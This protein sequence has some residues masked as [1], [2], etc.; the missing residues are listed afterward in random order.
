ME[1]GKLTINTELKTT[2]LENKLDK[3]ESELEVAETKAT[4]A[5]E[6]FKSLSKIIDGL[7]KGEI[8]T[9][10]YQKI[11]EQ[12]DKAE[13]VWKNA[14]NVVENLKN[15]IVET[16]LEQDKLIFD[17][18]QKSIKNASKLINKLKKV[19]LAVFGIRSVYSLVSK[20][21]NAYLSKDTELA[22][23]LQNVWVGLGSFLAPALEYVSNI[24][25]KALGYLN[26]F[27]KKLTGIDFIARANAKS[28]NKQANAQKN[29]NKQMFSFD[30]ANKFTDT[31]SLN[32]STGSNMINVPELDSRITSKLE[33][34]ALTLKENWDLIKYLGIAFGSVFGAVKVAQLLNSIGT[35]T[36]G[37][38]TLGG[39]IGSIP[40]LISISVIAVGI[41]YTISQ[42]SQLRADV[43]ETK[44][45][46]NDLRKNGSKTYKE[47]WGKEED[48]TKIIQQQKDQRLL[49]N[50]ALE[51][52]H[53]WLNKILGLDEENLQNAK[54]IV[55]N[56][57]THL[58]TLM[59]QYKQG[60]LN[61]EEQKEMLDNLIE[62]YNMNLK[63]IETLEK[64]GIETSEL[65][66]ITEQYGNAIGNVADGLGI[67][68]DNLNDM[69]IKSSEE[70]EITK[71]IYDNIKNINSTKLNDK[72][73]IYKITAKAD[74]TQASKDYSN[75]FSKLGQSVS[76]VFTP[77]SWKSGIVN[78]LK[79]I[80]KGKK[81]ATGGIVYNPGTGVPIGTSAIAG[82]NAPEAVLP[83]TDPEVMRKIGE[84]IGKWVSI[85][86]SLVNEMNGRVISRELKKINNSNNF[87][88]NV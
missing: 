9:E 62:Q 73:A 53:N 25:Q 51:D 36:G 41:A 37:M 13:I 67:S 46:L 69:I 17:K 34:L 54:Q 45:N 4:Q 72:S 12:A 57:K 56:S 10:K 1:I 58:D 23:K 6:K 49:A 15:K 44:D 71:G 82:E 83:F 19:G 64:N 75:F 20:A 42:I 76:T 85:N 81:L 2:K 39:A 32:S 8:N 79:S 50:E 31:S 16:Q 68:Q 18:N 38:E 60:N 35:I 47:I 30:E 78:S 63:I 55:E 87:E 48:I 66:E 27:I 33:K 5:E 7:G 28:L 14:T 74:T 3:L 70:K 43:E 84:E 59:K 61:N 40:T 65:K 80:W 52:S 22:E 77:S 11:A 86:V 26:V 24:L 29:L 88:K 21:S